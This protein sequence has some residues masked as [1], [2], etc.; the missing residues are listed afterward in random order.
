MENSYMAGTPPEKANC[1]AFI[2]NSFLDF[3][4]CLTQCSPAKPGATDG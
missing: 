3:R 2:E 4:F 1:D